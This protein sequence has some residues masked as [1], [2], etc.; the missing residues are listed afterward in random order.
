[1]KAHPPTTALSSVLVCV[2]QLLGAAP[3]QKPYHEADFRRMRVIETWRKYAGK[4]SWGKGQCLAILDDGCDLR[5]PQWQ[6][7][8]P[9]GKK[10]IASYNVFDHNDDPRPVPPGYHGTSVGYPSSLNC[11]GVCGVAYH[12][13]VAHVRCV[14]IVHLRKDESQTLAEGLQWVIDNREKYNITTVNLSPVD[15]QA[16]SAPLPTAI[17]AKLKRLREWNVWVSAPCGNNEHTIGVSWPACQPDCFA[18][19]ATKALDDT[20]YKDRS[21]KTDILVPA[22]ATSSSN[23][24]IAA[25]S[26]ILREA[27]IKTGYDWRSD[28]SNLPAAMMRIFQEAGVEVYDPATKRRFKRLDLLA[29][30][31]HVFGGSKNESLFQIPDLKQSRDEI[32]AAGGNDIQ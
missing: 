21:A 2:L 10:V 27:I 20:V 24:Y 11:N 15:D 25:A 22:G 9:W 13:H 19:G 5:A 7:P 6:A 1:V 29:A 16:H 23:A 18:I 32:Q 17:D 4:L 26:M 8:L 31:D 3:A 14:S 30:V 28:G 12:D